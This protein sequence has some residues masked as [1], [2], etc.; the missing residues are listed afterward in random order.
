MISIHDLLKETVER[1]ATDLHLT[2]GLPPEF[3]IN[4]CLV[5]SG[6]EVLSP[7]TCKELT[8]SLL[9][10]EQKKKLEKDYEVDF[11]F[12]LEK[13]S[14]FRGNTFFERGSV[15]CALRRIPI[16]IPT[17]RELGLPSS[18][19]SMLQ[20]MRGLILVTGPTGSGKS[21]TLAA[22]VDKINT[23]RACHIITIED[24]IEYVHNHKRAIV[25]QREVGQ[26][27]HSFARALK[28]VLRQDPDVILVGEMRDLETIGSALT[29]AETGHLVLSTLHTDSA[30]ESVNRIIDVFPPHQQ[31][32][33]RTQLSLTLEGVI[34]QRLLPRASGRGLVLALEIMVVTPAIRALIRDNRV[35]ELYGVIQTSQKYGMQTMNMSLISLVRKGVL[36][37]SNAL[38]ASPEP[39]ELKR[40]KEKGE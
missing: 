7:E 1:D 26:D 14:R 12:S 29:A 23:E 37:W 38:L 20:K 33:V 18:I 2:P 30:T 28:Y 17:L 40:M 32:Q 27:T 16:E 22:M 35:H 21:T 31:R 39:E 4:Q 34:V 13:I 11:A 36:S 25:Q 15:T 8:Y 3:R 5:S 24:P 19:D 9:T 10:T 6:Y